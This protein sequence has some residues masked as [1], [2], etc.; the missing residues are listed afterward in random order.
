[1]NRVRLVCPKCRTVY[2]FGPYMKLC[3]RCRIQLF[4][5]Y[6][7]DRSDFIRCMDEAYSR[8]EH[9]I[10]SFSC[11]LPVEGGETLGE[12]WT[13][14]IQAKSLSSSLGIRLLFK[15]ESFNPTG[16]FIDRGTSVDVSY[17]SRNMFK[18]ILSVSL[19]DYAV[20]LS[21]YATRYNIRVVHYIPRD[22]DLWKLYRISIQSSRVNFIDDYPSGLEK[23]IDRA[24]ER[25]MYPSISTS[26]TV[27]DGYRTMVFELYKH[28]SR[29]I[30]WIAIPIGEGVLATAIYKG[31]REF[32]EYTNIDGTRILG[33]RLDTNKPSSIPGVSRDLVYELKIYMTPTQRF[34]D[35]IANTDS[36][37]IVKV[38]ENM[39][40][41]SAINLVKNEGIYIDPIG[42]TSLAGVVEAVN[43]GIIDGNE[44]VVAIISGSPSKDP[45]V[46][47]SFIEGDTEA[48][49]RVR[50]IYVEEYDVS[51]IQR[52]I[53][54]ILYEK[55]ALYLYAIWRELVKRG[56]TISLQTL[57]HHISKLMKYLLIEPLKMEEGGRTYYRLTDLGLETLSRLRE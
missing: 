35:D 32:L 47:Y 46:L 52:E 11:L 50:R 10:W 31:L 22:I 41:G 40:I 39:V 23:A 6:D 4:I 16:T 37:K 57:Y 17:A 51:R 54:R 28:I 29:G 38:D 48:V 36:F 5:E 44:S 21:T 33:V 3:P 7:I 25:E 30:D 43:M 1:M 45:Y 12:G 49:E 18:N 8:H 34:I 27:I 14:L 55:K 56:Y 24:R 42:A 15:N 53:M 20:S 13:P 19:G 9:G 26:P 2:E